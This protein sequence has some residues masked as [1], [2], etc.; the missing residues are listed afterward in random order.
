MKT[1]RFIALAFLG[2]AV[3]LAL[4]TTPGSVHP[5]EA[6]AR[7]A[8]PSATVPDSGHISAAPSTTPL[9]F[10]EHVGQFDSDVRLQLPG[11]DRTIWLADDAIW[12]RLTGQPRG[13]HCYGGIPDRIQGRTCRPCNR[14]ER[15]GMAMGLV[16]PWEEDNGETD[17]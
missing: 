9:M 16:S 3:L 15:V 5:P 14:G 13:G 4:L 12:V 17:G 10:I 2:S 6:H 8:P 1:Q 11:G 7:P